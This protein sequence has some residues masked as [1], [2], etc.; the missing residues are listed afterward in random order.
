MVRIKKEKERGRQEIMLDGYKTYLA[1][2]AAFLTA[3]GLFIS[4]Y[5]NEGVIEPTA[6]ITAF[7]ALSLLFLRQSIRRC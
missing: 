5:L 4:K 2:L 7:I 6:L 1:A 3:L